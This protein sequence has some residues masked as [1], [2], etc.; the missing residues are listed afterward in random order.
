MPDMALDPVTA[1]LDIGGKL[2]DRLWP[3][4]ED[5][6]QAQI[7]LL[8]LQQRGELTGLIERA[9]IVRAEAG[10]EHWLTAM[11]RP[12]VMLVF[13][14]LIVARWFGW[15]T[16]GLTEAEYLKLWS[17]VEFGLGGYVVSRGVE[18]ITPAWADAIRNRGK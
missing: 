17:I 3:N 16:P 7:A 18:K 10:S 15:A 12:I 11:W 14:G 8:E 1:A 5:R 2:I 4:P 9:G 6:A 13:A